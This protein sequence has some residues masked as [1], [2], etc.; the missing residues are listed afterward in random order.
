M[1]AKAESSLTNA[2]WAKVESNGAF[3]TQIS[4]RRDKLSD[5][6]TRNTLMF[7]DVYESRI[8]QVVKEL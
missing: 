3:G 6:S 2:I 4:V 7:A 8:Q 5:P 1:L